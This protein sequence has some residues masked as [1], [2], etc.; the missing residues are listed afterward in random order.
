M[1]HRYIQLL[2]LGVL[3][4][5]VSVSFADSDIMKPYPLPEAGYDRMVIHLEPL[6]NEDLLKVGIFTGSTDLRCLLSIE[7]SE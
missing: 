5:F 7:S 1:M 3:V 2:T 4:I 6:G